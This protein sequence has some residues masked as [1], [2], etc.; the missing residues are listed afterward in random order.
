MNKQIKVNIYRGLFNTF[1]TVRH[2]K[3][4]IA[5]ARCMSNLD[6]PERLVNAYTIRL[7]EELMRKVDESK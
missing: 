5:I 2:K 3:L 6:L 7:E 4:D 1:V